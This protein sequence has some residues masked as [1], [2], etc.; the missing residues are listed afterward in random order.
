MGSKKLPQMNPLE[1]LKVLDLSRIL[2]G[3][4][5][6]QTLADL[7]A[8]VIKIER[9]TK[10]DD[11]RSWG[12]PFLKSGTAEQGQQSAYFLCANR[13]KQ[14]IAIDI[15]SAAGQA[16]IKQMVVDADVLIENYK[17]GGLQLYGL[18]YNSLAKLNPGLI[19]CSITGFGQTGPYADKAGYD[20][21][22][23]ASSGLMS[24]TGEAD[25]DGGGPTK[26]GVAITDI[27]T[28]LYS[29]IAIQAA[30]LER[31]RTGKGKH[32]DMALLDCATA[33]LANQG[34]NYLVGGVVPQRLGN[35]HPN[36]VPYQSFATADGYIVI[37]VGND[38]QFE[39]LCKV[40]EEPTWS[41]MAEYASNAARIANC[42]ALI[43]K[44][45]AK[46]QSESSAYWLAKLELA[47][48]PAA[49][50]SRVDEA[51]N[52]PNLQQRDMLKSYDHPLK[53]DLKLV[54]SP[55]QFVGETKRELSPPPMLNEHKRDA[56]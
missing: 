45:S 32:I 51:F 35:R 40:V 6:S 13:G 3:P 50:I 34:S 42:D 19:Y 4:W 36:I 49:Q 8:E 14:S 23:Q 39:Q 29:V 24:I 27:A 16:Q 47:N 5:A 21:M 1:G 31:E 41:T 25:E 37:A 55:I 52:D 43:N 53:S 22:I 10:G 28:G 9:P 46:L 48:I 15:K 56:D 44:L 7:G 33:L 38:S 26:V 11:T 30:L 17:V 18:D 20:L 12:P 2:A 54:A